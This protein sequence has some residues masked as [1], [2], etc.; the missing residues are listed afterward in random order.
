MIISSDSD[1]DCE[2]SHTS[3]RER[4]ENNNTYE[5]TVENLTHEPDLNPRET[6]EMDY[7]DDSILP[8]TGSEEGSEDQMSDESE[9]FRSSQHKITR[10]LFYKNPLKSSSSTVS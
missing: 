7:T 8:D 9:Y 2:Q 6:N 1:S 5:G 10:N 4:E 3:S